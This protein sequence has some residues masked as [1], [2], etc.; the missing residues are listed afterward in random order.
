M[1]KTS[2]NRMFALPRKDHS[3]LDVGLRARGKEVMSA[4]TC[5]ILRLRIFQIWTYAPRTTDNRIKN[6]R[7]KIAL[8]N[9]LPNLPLGKTITVLSTSYSITSSWPFNQPMYFIT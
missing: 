6:D 2:R 3:M 1:W 7:T 4:M 8:A 5:E 9:A